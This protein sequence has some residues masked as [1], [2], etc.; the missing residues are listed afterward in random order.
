MACASQAMISAN[1]CTLTSPRLFKKYTNGNKRKLKLFTVRASSDDTECNTE[2]CAPEKEVGKV[3]MEWLAGEKTKVVGTFPPSKRGWTGYVEKDTAGQTNIYSVEPAVYVAESAISSG[4]AGTSADGSEGTAAR[5]AG[6][7][8]ISVAAASL[9][10]LLVG[11]NPSNN[12]TTAEY[13]GPSLSY[14]INKFKPGEIIQAAVPSQT[15]PPSSIQAD[16]SMPEVPEIQVQSAPDVSEVPVQ[17]QSEPRAL[18]FKCEQCF[19]GKLNW[20]RFFNSRN[21]FFSSILLMYTR[22]N[23]KRLLTRRYI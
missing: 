12:I 11:K 6:L 2:E 4:S 15:E 9:I 1:T 18:N 7:G 22:K 13:K 16:S 21:S 5:A 3:S 23:M 19:L 8:L 20:L 10:L 14:Y 17:S